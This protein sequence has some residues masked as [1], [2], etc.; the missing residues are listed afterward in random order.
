[1]Q[2]VPTARRYSPCKRVIFDDHKCGGRKVCLK[3]QHLSTFKKMSELSKKNQIEYA[4]FIDLYNDRNTFV[5]SHKRNCVVNRDVKKIWPKPFAYH[6]HT[7][8]ELFT[9]APGKVLTTLP[10]D[11]DFMI[12]IKLYPYMQANCICDSEG[13]YYVD[14]VDAAT[15]L[16]LPL[17][18]ALSKTMNDFRN[19]DHLREKKK[20]VEGVEYFETSIVE[21][22]QIINVELNSH[23]HDLYGLTIKY[24]TFDEES[25]VIRFEDESLLW[26]L[27][28]DFNC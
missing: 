20:I 15:K 3:K 21:W 18:H 24:Y 5:T 25:V 17:P 10:S 4:G 26:N 19:M 13:F 14:I 7:F 2:C 8:P 12:Y 22:K 11:E 6:T 27:I 28:A 16:N 1:M 23:L 9:I